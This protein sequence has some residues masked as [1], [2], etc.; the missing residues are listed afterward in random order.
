M[1]SCD[2][3][4]RQFLNLTHPDLPGEGLLFHCPYVTLAVSEHQL[5]F[6]LPVTE[7]F[8]NDLPYSVMSVFL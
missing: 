6:L 8:L 4:L 7:H 1:R 2:I 3:D 5:T